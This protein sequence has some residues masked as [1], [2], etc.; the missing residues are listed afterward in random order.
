MLH[1]ML[2]LCGRQ[3]GDQFIAEEMVTVFVSRRLYRHTLLLASGLSV[4]ILAPTAAAQSAASATAIGPLGGKPL[5]FE[6]AT[7]RQNT[8]GGRGGI[9]VTDDGWTM[10]DFPFVAAIQAAYMPK[11]GGEAFFRSDEIEGLPSWASNERYDIIAKVPEEDLAEWKQPQHR[12]EMMHA[13]LQQLLVERC[14]LAVHRGSKQTSILALTVGKE[15]PKLKPAD[16]NAQHSDG[17]TVPGIGTVVQDDAHTMHFY[18]ATTAALAS[19]F[20]KVTGGLQVQDRTGLTGRYD[21]VVHLPDPPSQTE[22]EAA[23]S[24]DRETM[25]ILIANELG[26]KLEPAKSTVETLVIDHVERPSEN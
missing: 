4:G 13:M 18:N 26:L 6:V 20:S 11:A 14:G 5:A 19:L 24:A 15:G 2:G 17:E 23:S 8:S 21:I 12:A 1:R 10:T 16:P 22:G 25:A 9:K 3:E 7:I